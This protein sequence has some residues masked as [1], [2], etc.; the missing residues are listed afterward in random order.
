M[1]NET[2]E[3]KDIKGYEGKYQVSNLGKIRNSKGIELSFQDSHGYKRYTLWK[4]NKNKLTHCLKNSVF[5]L[6]IL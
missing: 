2:E 6:D 5:L 1:S 3:W 4:N